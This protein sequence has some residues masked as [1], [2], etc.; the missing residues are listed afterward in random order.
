MAQLT[1]KYPQDVRVVFRHFPLPSHPNAL[2]AAY[3]AEA[4]GVQD[5]FFEMS[6]AIFAAQAEWGGL[7]TPEAEAWFIAKAGELGLDT[8]KF[9]ADVQTEAVQKPV[10]DSLQFAQTVGIPGTP[11][12]FIN[13]L[14]YQNNMDIESLS[15]FVEYFKL[16]ERAYTNCPPMVVDPAKQYEATIKTEVGEI[17]LKLYA[18]K[19]P[20]AVN[21]FVFLAREGWFD[22]SPFHRVL[23]G[24]VAQGGDPSGSGFGSPGYSFKNENAE[25]VF[26]REG[27]LAMANSGPDTN[28]SQFFITFG[29]QDALNGGYTIFG[30][31]TEGMDV[32]RKITLRDPASG[33]ALPPGTKIL[34]VDIREK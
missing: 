21:S 11:F 29:P 24:F 3:A 25:A 1:E 26:D 27:L 2:V 8:E 23:E 18:D 6:N 30:E 10:N 20:L 14:P 19:A 4:A 22:N 13:G 17:V 5:K 15:T 34:D 9:K 12:L 7:S 16:E 32:V 28:G 33:G 31:V